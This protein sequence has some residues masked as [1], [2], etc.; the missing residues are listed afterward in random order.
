MLRADGH[1]VTALTLPGM[2]SKDA[3]RSSITFQDH[4]D[5]IIGALEAAERRPSLPSTAR[6]ASAAT[7]PATRSRNGSPRWSTSTPRPASRRSTRTSRTSRSRWSGRTIAAEENLDGLSEEQQATFRERAVPVP[8]A[9]LRERLHVHQ[10]R[11]TRHPLDRHRD[12]LH[13]R[14]LP[15]VRQGAPGLGVPRRHAGAAGRDLGR[16]ADQPLADVVATDRAR[17]DHRGHRHEGR[18]RGGSTAGSAR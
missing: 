5:A 16:P 7:R 1:D 17:R 2:E 10:R 11:P 9:M 3:D 4:V 12:R 18:Q 15:E 13:G 14:R 6:P 8:G